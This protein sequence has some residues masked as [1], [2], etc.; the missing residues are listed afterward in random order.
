MI[1][2]LIVLWILHHCWISPGKLYSV[3][4][5]IMQELP[6]EML[7]PVLRCC[8]THWSWCSLLALQICE[9]KKH[10]TEGQPWCSC[11]ILKW[12]KL[13]GSYLGERD[14][15][16][17]GRQAEVRADLW[18]VLSDRNCKYTFF[19]KIHLP[20]PVLGSLSSAKVYR[21]CQAGSAW[22]FRR[23]KRCKFLQGAILRVCSGRGLLVW[24]QSELVW[25]SP[26]P[27]TIQTNITH[28]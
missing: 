8:H 27:A 7:C 1:F 20:L 16:V 10:M 9:P 26:I 14:S 23:R 15:A 28:V 24:P 17:L 2:H 22:N 6:G 25:F 19:A 4:A 11:C 3:Q 5:E 21:Q 13:S 18:L 12:R